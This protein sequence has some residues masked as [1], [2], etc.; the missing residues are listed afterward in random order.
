MFFSRSLGTMSVM[1]GQV[2]RG[3]SA[4][5]RVFEYMELRPSMSLCGGRTIL[6]RNVKGDISLKNVK[7]SYPT[8]PDQVVIDN[9][10]LD[11]E[12]GKMVALCGASGSGK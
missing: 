7:F 9:L 3:M 2:V 1:F 6:K 12:A 10:S 4:G 8:R 11:V 5:A